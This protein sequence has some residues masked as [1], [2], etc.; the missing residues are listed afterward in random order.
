LGWQR[1]YV[2]QGAFS[3]RSLHRPSYL[4]NQGGERIWGNATQAP[5]DI[6]K[7]DHTHGE[8]IAFR[9]PQMPPVN[10]SGSDN[11]LMAQLERGN[12]TADEAGLWI[13]EHT[14]STFQKMIATNYSFGFET[15]EK[16]L[17]KNDADHTKWTNPLEVRYVLYPFHDL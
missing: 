16:K 5:D 3:H 2:D 11:N 10:D 8:L 4:R 6:D 17:K 1:K 7:F 12:M 14:P 13:L 9:E 15:N